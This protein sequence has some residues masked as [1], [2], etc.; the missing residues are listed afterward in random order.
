MG[1]STGQW[2]DSTRRVTSGERLI[3]PAASLWNGIMDAVEKCRSGARTQVPSFSETDQSGIV[4]VVNKTG[5][6][7]DRF[8]VVGLGDPLNTPDTDA[9]PDQFIEY[10]LPFEA[11]APD[12]DVHRGKFAVLLES[13]EV[14]GAGPAVLSGV[15]QVRVN[16]AD[17]NTVRNCAEIVDAQSGYLRAVHHGSATIL[18]REGGTG[19]QWAV[20]RLGQRSTATAFPITVTSADPAGSQGTAS[21]AA[22]WLYDVADAITGETLAEDVDPTGSPHLWRRPSVGQMVKAT[23]GLAY[24]NDSDALVVTWLNEVADQ[25]ACGGS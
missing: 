18:W 12:I 16:V 6:A 7:L 8:D 25:E 14:N 1:G 3:M 11:V 19:E 10:P 5:A 20:V 13:L 9:D 2:G 22:S 24:W 4:M 23:A 21:T 15:C 17:E